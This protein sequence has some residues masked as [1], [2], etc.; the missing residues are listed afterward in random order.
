MSNLLIHEP[1]LQV[2]PT[3][4]VK[5]G[6]NEAILVQQIHYWL[7]RSTTTVGGHR[8]VYNSV[9]RWREQFP[10]WSED[11]I[12]RTL[13]SLRTSGIVVADF[14]SNDP[15]D[16]TLYYRIDYRNLPVSDGGEVRHSIAASCGTERPQDAGMSNRT[17]TTTETTTEIPR[18]RKR[19]AAKVS[20]DD[21]KSEGVEEQHAEA[22]L[23]L[24][25]AKRLPLTTGAWDLVR[26]AG[27][28]CGLTPA[29][30]VR[31]CV[32]RGWAAFRADW[33]VSQKPAASRKGAGR[34]YHDLSGMDY[35][36]GVN[37]DGSF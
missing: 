22:W 32:L 19:A 28:E 30:T 17:E 29:Q 12:A 14:L 13:K 16:R 10:F 2:L 27:A 23:E 7:Q 37:D 36:K 24:R 8:W 9:A 33:F 34:T 11:T 25:K 1:P 18:A 6:L 5:I 4:A 3:L 15:R 35:T 31:E 21:L 20:V 26:S